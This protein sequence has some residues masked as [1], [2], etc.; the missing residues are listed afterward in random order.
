MRI[1]R[2]RISDQSPWRGLVFLA[3]PAIGSTMFMVVY[4]IV[5]MFWLG[6]WD[7]NPLLLYMPLLKESCFFSGSTGGTG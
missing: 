1:E 2:N 5:D 3:L 6:N 7:Q 4:E